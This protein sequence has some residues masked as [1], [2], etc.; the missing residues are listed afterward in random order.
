MGA[1]RIRIKPKER[2]AETQT[3]IKKETS[4]ATMSKRTGNIRKRKNEQKSLYH[5]GA[6]EGGE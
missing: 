4:R 5:Q 6:F 2:A 1:K 3:K